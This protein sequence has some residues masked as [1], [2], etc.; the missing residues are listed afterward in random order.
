MNKTASLMPARPDNGAPDGPPDGGD[1]VD[2]IVVGRLGRP[3][4]VRGD[5]TV[6][7][8]T[9]VPERR[10]APGARLRTDRP[11]GAGLVVSAARWHAGT[12]L[13][14][15]EGV[16][17]RTAAETLRG[18]TVAIDAADAGDP[19]DAESDADGA[20]GEMYW[21][22]DLVGLRASTVGGEAV[23]VVA[24]VVHTPAGELLAIERPDGR[25]VLV[26]FV[27]DIVP[28]VEPAQG[29]LVIDPPDGLLELGT[30]G[31]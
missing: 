22:R 15:F 5:V 13:V 20:A 4:G 9:D 14:H 23:G 16:D 26:P 25:E 21:D 3:H 6:D 18:L 29:R 1:A 28:V 27:R 11:G 2:T 31:H 30:P 8:R 19:D 17:D 7:V 24:D 10:F 12:L